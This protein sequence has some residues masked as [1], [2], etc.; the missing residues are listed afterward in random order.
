M[1]NFYAF[2]DPVTG[3]IV[4]RTTVYREVDDRKL[5]PK[6]EHLRRQ[7]KPYD[8]AAAEQAASM[9]L[10]AVKSDSVLPMQTTYID[11]ETKEHK[12]MGDKPGPHHEWS[13][14]TH[15]WVFK[16]EAVDTIWQNISKERDRRSLEGGVKFGD[17]WFH[18][19]AVSRAK[20]TNIVLTEPASTE[21]KA[22]G[23]KWVVMGPTMA[24]DVLLAI[25]AN[26]LAIF[27]AAQAH[28][29]ALEASPN[30][31]R[32]DWYGGWPATYQEATA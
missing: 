25:A 31:E 6:E 28:R 15:Q 7:P 14:Q 30:P 19:N 8:E 4:Q 32:Y 2:Y 21:W 11:V 26:D 24:R 13:W 3:R 27:E 9:G 10:L 5:D 22:M 18:T 23:G 17:V 12:S 29:K 1:E 20:Y 16:P